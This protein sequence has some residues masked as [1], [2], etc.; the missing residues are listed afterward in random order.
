VNRED[1]GAF[2]ISPAGTP[3]KHGTYP[4]CFFVH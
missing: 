1:A 4:F 2:Q 3:A